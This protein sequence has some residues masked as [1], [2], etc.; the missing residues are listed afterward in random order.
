M[1]IKI[2]NTVSLN[3]VS[4]NRVQLNSTGGAKKNEK[5]EYIRFADAEAKR[6]CVE[7]FDT[8]GDGKVSFAE[9]SA[10]TTFVDAFKNNKTVKTFN[11]IQYFDNPQCDM[12]SKMQLSG[13]EEVK[14]IK[15]ASNAIT[16][17]YQYCNS[18]KNAE[19][20]EVTNA[21]SVAYI[22]GS[23]SNL[24]AAKLFNLKK[25]RS[26]VG[27]FIGCQ[28]LERVEFD[29]LSRI[30]SLNTTFGNCYN[31]IDFVVQRLPNIALSL[32]QSSKL[33]RQSIET[34]LNALPQSTTFPT[35]T[36]HVD[37]I[38][39]YEE[40]YGIESVEDACIEKGWMLA[41]AGVRSEKYL[42]DKSGEIIKDKNGINLTTK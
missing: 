21:P 25:V 24:K 27:A 2:L 37:A 1:N 33:S 11:E 39:R 14:V 16:A 3:R 8:D 4:P 17:L 9:A 15:I 28:A 20:E 18:I 38:D 13:L 31:L 32:A 10:V 34:I 6:I 26:M 29:D 23:C 36:L 19:I 35:L 5:I 22:F 41:E 40:V 42:Y 7:N 12:G 30:T